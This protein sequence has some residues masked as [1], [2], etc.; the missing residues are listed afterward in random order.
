MEA[1]YKILHFAF[2]VNR[3]LTGFYF[4]DASSMMYHARISSIYKDEIF[5]FINTE[6]IVALRI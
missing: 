3:A 4:C 1:I 5:F 6:Q 2:W